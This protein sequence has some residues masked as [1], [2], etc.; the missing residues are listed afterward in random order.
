MALDRLALSGAV[1][2]VGI[3]VEEKCPHLV[4]RLLYH[5]VSVATLFPMAVKTLLACK[6][7]FRRNVADVWAPHGNMIDGECLIEKV[8]NF[9]EVGRQRH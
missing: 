1:M 6:M 9:K 3:Q 2:L 5:L 4:K 7:V 8:E